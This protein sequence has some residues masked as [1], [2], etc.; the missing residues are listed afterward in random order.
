MGEKEK[1]IKQIADAQKK[2]KKLEE[3]E[4]NSLKY[5]AIKKLEE[6]TSEEKIKKFD[7]LYNSSLSEL[8]EI[9]R[10]KYHD[11]DCVHYFWEASMEILARDRDKFWE[12]YNSIID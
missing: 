4:Q 2:L 9:E 12:Y 6:Y 10:K 7:A 5:S 1:L 11:D 3:Q 8:E